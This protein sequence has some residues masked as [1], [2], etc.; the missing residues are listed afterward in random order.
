M[1]QMYPSLPCYICF[2]TGKI[3]LKRNIPVQPVYN[4][5]R[6][7]RASAILSFHAL[8]W[9]D[10]SGRFAGKTNE[11]F[12]KVFMTCDDDILNALE[13]LDHWDLSQEGIDQFEWFACQL[14]TSKI[15]TKVNDFRWLLYSNCTA[16]EEILPP[17]T[18]SLTM[19]IQRTHYVAMIW[20]KAREI[21]PRLWLGVWHDQ[22]VLNSS[23]MFESS[24]RCSC[25]ELGKV[26]LHT[27]MQEGV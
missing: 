13:C 25:N 16:E 12:F 8:I 15:F 7:S 3:N 22:R 6:H 19:H 21:H 2:H 14:Y 4:K 26:W 20:R 18:G 17:T 27:R 23:K 11:W 9:W 5:L 24:S 10:M 1:V